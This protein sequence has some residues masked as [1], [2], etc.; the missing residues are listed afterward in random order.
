MKNLKFVGIIGLIVLLFTAVIAF[1]VQTVIGGAGQADAQGTFENGARTFNISMEQWSFKP[2]GIR[3]M[4]GETVKFVLT[5]TDVW[6]G[7]A[8]N[9][10]GVN[11]AV[12]GGK[13]V[14]GEVV[15][16]ADIPEG[17]YTMYCSVFC[18]LGHPYLKGEAII[19]NPKLF[20]GVGVG[21]V[22]PYAATLL[23]T[24]ILA[25]VLVIGWRRTR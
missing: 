11:L 2:A 7:F 21:R 15:I 6:H 20:L 16:P 24:T 9:E 3:M 5:S 22:L 23:M 18:G 10:L 13:T 4:P 14:V 1:G 19:G 25:A 8:V 17:V 12:P